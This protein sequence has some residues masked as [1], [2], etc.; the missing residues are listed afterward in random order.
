MKT[1]T[2]RAVRCRMTDRLHNPWPNEAVVPDAEVLLCA[3]HLGR[4][5]ALMN[6]IRAA[7]SKAGVSP[8]QRA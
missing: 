3:K 8:G 7:A 2:E 6:E 4:A 5:A 1:T